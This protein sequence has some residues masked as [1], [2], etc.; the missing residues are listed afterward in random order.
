MCFNNT[1]ARG[2]RLSTGGPYFTKIMISKFEA[3]GLIYV[4]IIEPLAKYFYSG[5]KTEILRAD[6]S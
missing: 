6:Q 4:G 5:S 1:Y 2:C 3:S